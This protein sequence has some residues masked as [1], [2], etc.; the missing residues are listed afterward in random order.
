MKP[1]M[2]SLILAGAICWV[3]PVMAAD[4]P[5]TV[6]AA[7]TAT[8]GAAAALPAEVQRGWSRCLMGRI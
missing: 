6:P 4:V 5:A 8:E 1:G 2:L 7:M 3:I